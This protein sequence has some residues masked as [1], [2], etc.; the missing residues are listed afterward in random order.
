MVILVVMLMKEIVMKIVVVISLWVMMIVVGIIVMVLMMMAIIVTLAMV[1]MMLIIN[2]STSMGDGHHDDNHIVEGSGGDAD[3]TVDD[4]SD[5]GDNDVDGDDGDRVGYGDDD[6]DHDSGVDGNANID[7]G[8]LIIMVTVVRERRGACFNPLLPISS[9]PK[10]NARLE[11][12]IDKTFEAKAMQ[13]APSP[14]PWNDTPPCLSLSMTTSK[15]RGTVFLSQDHIGLG[16]LSGW[17]P[18]EVVLLGDVSAYK[19][20][21]EEPRVHDGF[22]LTLFQHRGKPSLPGGTWVCIIRIG[23]GCGGRSG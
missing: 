9:M 7:D 19:V 5:G 11:H 14:K 21:L 4:G 17:S 3:D 20:R 6:G 8:D 15:I 1:V 16:Q 23:V 22:P 18:G 10:N 13:L 2:G 12:F